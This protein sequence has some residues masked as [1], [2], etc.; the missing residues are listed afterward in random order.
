M[1]SRAVKTSGTRNLHLLWDQYVD[2]F[3]R[4][5]LEAHS[6]FTLSCSES[7]LNLVG[8]DFAIEERRVHACPQRARGHR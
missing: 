8:V 1:F 3:P 6:V 5:R 2:G 4:V 7:F